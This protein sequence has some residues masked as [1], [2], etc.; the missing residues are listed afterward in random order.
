MEALNISSLT[1]LYSL[2]YWK[3]CFFFPKE[4]MP[5]FWGGG[6]IWKGGRK[7]TICS[8]NSLSFFAPILW[9]CPFVC[10][11]VVA[12]KL[13]STVELITALWLQV[14]E[15]LQMK[16]TS[17]GEPQTQCSWLQEEQTQCPLALICFS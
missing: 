3:F 2:D 9:P 17:D 6:T 5:F 15:T 13:S 10:D 7:E 16:A 8:Y 4:T 11:S 12:R 1:I 14:A